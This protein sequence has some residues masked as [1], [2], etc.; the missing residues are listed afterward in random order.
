MTSCRP[1]LNPE[2]G[3]SSPPI[4][5]VVDEDY[6]YFITSD[7]ANGDRAQRIVDLIDELIAADGT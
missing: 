3:I 6:P 4:N 1:L 2:S 5:A 7:W